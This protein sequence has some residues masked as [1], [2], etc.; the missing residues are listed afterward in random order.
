MPSALK[1]ISYNLYLHPDIDTGIFTGQEKILIDVVEETSQII[2][3]SNKLQ[4]TSVY[5][6]ESG[7]DVDSYSL[8]TEREFLVINMKTPLQQNTKVTLAIIFEGQMLNK[9]VG[10]YSST[11]VTPE[12]EKR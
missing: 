12:N 2:L 10:L 3:H 9:I 11:Y 8:D 4:I 5:T 6:L 7:Y 1:P